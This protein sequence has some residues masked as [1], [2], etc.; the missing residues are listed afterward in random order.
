LIDTK[1]KFSPDVAQRLA[2]DKSL[3]VMIY[4]AGDT[5]P[6]TDIAF[7]QQIEIR[8]NGDEV[9]ANMRGLKNKPGT[10]RPADITSMLHKNATYENTMLVTY[11]LTAKVDIENHQV[12][13]KLEMLIPE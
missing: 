11:A 7:P 13:G 10:T 9:K 4:C 12:T 8:I 6:Q 2:A 1:I 5:H 3:R